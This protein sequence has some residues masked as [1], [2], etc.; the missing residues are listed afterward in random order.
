[1]VA[2]SASFSHGSLVCGLWLGGGGRGG[3]VPMYILGTFYIR[4]F[5]TRAT[6]WKNCK[7]NCTVCFLIFPYIVALVHKKTYV[8]CTKYVRRHT[9]AMASSRQPQTTNKRT[10][11]EASG[12]C[13]HDI[14]FISW[15]NIMFEKRKSI[16]SICSCHPLNLFCIGGL[17]LQFFYEG[18]LKLARS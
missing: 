8:E 11:A 6:I 15:P 4:F 9:P 1:V 16:G 12:C 14:S 3:S 5:C 10:M 17:R 13:Y 18:C 2:K 7:A